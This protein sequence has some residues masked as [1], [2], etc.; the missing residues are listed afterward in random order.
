MR[1]MVDG[2]VLMDGPPGDYLKKPPEFVAE[3]IKKGAKTAPW[4]KALMVTMADAAIRQQD[5][6]LEITTTATGWTLAATLSHA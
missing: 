1:I 3:S 6:T 2:N 5:L 4:M